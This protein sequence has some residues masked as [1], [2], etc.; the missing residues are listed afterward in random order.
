M[1]LWRNKSTKNGIAEHL[2]L[3]HILEGTYYASRY[4]FAM[5]TPTQEC[6]VAGAGLQKQGHI[7]HK[8]SLDALQ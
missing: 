8:V 5:A 1:L 2:H 4:S 6:S 7:D 3:A